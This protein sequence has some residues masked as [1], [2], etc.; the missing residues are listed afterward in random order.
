[1]LKLEVDGQTIIYKPVNASKVTPVK[2]TQNGKDIIRYVD[3]WKGIDVDY[4]VQ[5]SAVKEYVYI[6]DA[7]AAPDYSFDITGTDFTP[8]PENPGGFVQTNGKGAI[9]S[10][11]VAVGERGIISEPV[12]KQTYANGKLK[13]EVDQTF[14]KNLP[15]SDFPIVIDPTWTR[16]T[17]G[18]LVSGNYGAFKSDGYVCNSTVC[19]INAGSLN[20]AGYW[21]TWRGIFHVP[22][23]DL[24]QGRVLTGASLHLKQMAPPPNVWFGNTDAR[25]FAVSHLSCWAYNCIDYGAPRAG[26]TLTTEGWMDVTALYQSRI[27]IGDWGAWMVINGEESASSN[28]KSFNPEQTWVDFY[29]S[30]APT[31]SIPISPADKSVATTIQPTLNSGGATDPDGDPITYSFWVCEDAGCNSPIVGAGDLA[32]PTWTLPD[33]LLKDGQTYYWR[34]FTKDAYSG[35][36]PGTNIRSFRVDLRTGKDPTQSYDSAGPVSV[37]LATGNVSSSLNTHSIK[38]LGGAV[39]VGLEYNSPLLARQGVTADYFNNNAFT[40]S[41]VF[42]RIEPAVDNSWGATSPGNGV[43]VDNFSARYTGYFISP[44]TGTINFGATSDDGVQIWADDVLV[45]NS[46]GLPFNGYGNGVS[47]VEGQVVKLKVQYQELTGA[48]AMRLYVRGIGPDRL[49]ESNWLRTEPIQ[50]SVNVG[51]SARYYTDD[52]SHNFDETRFQAGRRESTSSLIWNSGSPLPGTVPTNFMAK[53]ST[54]F[55]APTAGSYQFGVSGDDG[56]RLYTNDI[57]QVDKWASGGAPIGTTAWGAAVTLAAGQSI[58]L[59]GEMY[60]LGGPASLTMYVRTNGVDQIIPTTMV[61]STVNGLTNGWQMSIDADG[62]LAYD[63]AQLN[64]SSIVF[65]D[66]SGLKKEY[67]LDPLKNAYQPPEGEQGIVTKN[68]N[69]TITL[70]EADGRVY[71]FG[72]DGRLSTA[73]SATDDLKPAALKYEY[74]GTPARLTKVIDGVDPSRSGTLY[75]GSDSVCGTSPSGFD[76]S[77][78]VNTLCAYKTTDGDTTNFY[79]TSGQMTRIVQ[80]GGVTTDMAYDSK[81]RIVSVRGG[82]AYDLI[83]SGQRTNGD[84]GLTYEISYDAIGRASVIREPSLT[85]GSARREH[86]YKYVSGDSMQWTDAT[87]IPGEATATSPS[88]VNY[89]GDKI[90]LFSRNAANNA[91][92]KNLTDNT[93][94]DWQNLGGGILDYPGAASWE[95]GRMDMFVRGTDNNLYTMVYQ[96]GAWGAYASLANGTGITSAPS[97]TSWS[98]NRIDVVAK[99]PA[100]QLLH[101]A[102]SPGT[103]WSGYND[104]GGCISQAPAV[105]T[106]GVDRLNMYVQGCAPAG[107]PTSFF[108]KYWTGGFGDFLITSEQNL[109]SGIQSVSIPATKNIHIVA[110]GPTGDLRYR[111]YNGSNWLPWQSLVTC[112]Q[113]SPAITNIGDNNLMIVYRGCDGFF[114]Q[115][116]GSKIFGKTV[117]SSTLTNQPNGYSDKVEYDSLFRTV[118]NFDK[119]GL[120]SITD[121]HPYKDISY[122]STDAINLKSTTVYD[123]KDLPIESYGPAPKAWYGADGRPLA[124]YATQVPKSETK[125]DEGINGLSVAWYNVKGSTFFG[126]PK[127]HTTGINPDVDKTW[128]T[129]DF[130]ISTPFTPDAGMDGY[131]FSATGT[132]TFPQSGTYTFINYF[133]D[134]SRLYVDDR[135][136]F[137]SVDTWANRSLG[138]AQINPSGTFVAVGGKTYRFRLDYMHINDAVGQGAIGLWMKGP[139]ITNTHPTAD[140]GVDKF[141]SMLK[142]GYNLVTSTKSFDSVL[143]DVSTSNNYGNNPEFGQV[144]SAT[145][146]PTG[147]N[148]SSQATYEGGQT[149]GGFYRQTSKTLPGGNTTTYAYYGATEQLDNPCTTAVDPASQAGLGKLTTSQDP[150][151]A[152]AATSLTS[153][154]VYDAKGRAVASRANADPWTCVTYDTRGRRIKTVQPNI[155]GRIGR[156]V[157]ITY[158]LNGDPLRTRTTDS[159]VGSSETLVDFYGRQVSSTDVWSNTYSS[160][161]DSFG[162]V[163]SKV[164]PVGTETYAYD[165]LDRMSQYVLDGVTQAVMTYDAYS[166]VATIEYPEIKN[167]SGVKLKMTQVKR[168]NRER[169]TG[170]MYQTSDGKVFDE[171]VVM[172]QLGKIIGAT[173]TYDA[174]TLNSTFSLDKLGRMT[175]ATVG[176]TKY[177]YGYGAP[178]ASCSTLAGNNLNAQKDSNRTSYTVT[179][180]ATNAVTSSDTSCYDAADRLISSTDIQVGTPTYDDHGNTVSM[181]GAGVPI[182]FTYDSSDQNTKIEQGVNRVEY[183]KSPSGG[184]LRK[185]E[186][187]SGTLNKSYRYLA[188]GKILQT[189]SLT[190]ETLCTNLDTYLTLPGSI[191]LTKSPT[192]PDLSR[193]VVYSLKNYHGDTALTLSASG[194]STSSLTAYGP[195]GEKLVGGTLGAQTTA[196][197]SPTLTNASDTNMGWAASPSRKVEPLFTLAFIQMGARVYLPTLGRFL[198]RDP[199]EGGTLNDYVYAHDPVNLSDYTGQSF[200]GALKNVVTTAAKVL[201]IS[202]P[203]VM[204]IIAVAAVLTSKTVVAMVN[205][206]VGGGQPRTASTASYNWGKLQNTSADFGGIVAKSKG[207]CSSG[208]TVVNNT[209]RVSSPV[210][211]DNKETIGKYSGVLNGTI[212]TTSTSW[213]FKGELKINPEKYNYDIEWKNRFSTRNIGTATGALM[214]GSTSLL[215]NIATYGGCGL[216]HDYYINF[217]KPVNIDEQGVY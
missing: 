162:R 50:T 64:Q 120:F 60:N 5:G 194:V 189:C 214:S 27:N 39:G 111:I 174:Q 199:V 165:S 62:N 48:A 197:G 173:Q 167:A 63:Y 87:R 35:W 146:D 9:S 207:S 88:L 76:A 201:F 136:I 2:I 209:V 75:Y 163:T 180:L 3:L 154:V 216:P 210:G 7:D 178:S 155:N 73:T 6:N 100:N 160:T 78:P 127:L 17:S 91:V 123:R 36:Q 115:L 148:Y 211:I 105:S 68:A 70:Q 142:P 196:T 190:D 140:L 102:Y 22:F 61:A 41:P 31:Q 161:Y 45:T 67:K 16:R 42:S 25:S 171:T 74:A 29:T 202:S 138:V 175:S 80:P 134:A 181:A 1:M 110:R 95:D 18:T 108:E 129:R 168:D 186:Y 69:N 122:G 185:K 143:G 15:K 37:N 44:K 92:F 132:I 208:C 193:Q 66:A 159:L 96:N 133:D 71:V 113:E 52:G 54:Y 20:D 191:T 83:T 4:M 104:L 195:F 57:L 212:K 65:Y 166:R 151:G 11:T 198:Q 107:S 23:Q 101:R 139:G 213:S 183:L 82:L 170:V 49:V 46:S 206:A 59:R 10:L 141:G 21:K 8:D 51:Y 137:T 97:A 118:K 124:A 184:I 72:A 152:G 112:I 145:A 33:G 85:A 43:P 156:T 77:A 94:S 182:N 176:Q 203:I 153:S 30:G 34:S 128:V 24:V 98:T 53:L 147:L 164:S 13:V 28:Y 26:T 131:G 172:S 103:G 40:G 109:T 188:G 32:S 47:V 99:G 56:T 144:L 93:W 116:N 158:A 90:G 215:C 119:A 169:T 58:P 205:H 86:S 38:A 149:A 157:D 79:Y 135:S 179:N 117:M 81:G 204:P 187:L 14:V 192:N 217:D 89:G 177:D 12:T 125:Y 126:A 19:N 55:T 130:R 114:Y 200:W 84:A 121:Y 106:W 150:D